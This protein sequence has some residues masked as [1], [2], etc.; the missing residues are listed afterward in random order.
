MQKLKKIMPNFEWFTLHFHLNK[1]E[2]Y[3]IL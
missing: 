2:A 1:S 3:Q